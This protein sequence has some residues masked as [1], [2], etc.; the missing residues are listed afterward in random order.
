MW[1]KAPTDPEVFSKQMHLFPSLSTTQI[2]CSWAK[3]KSSL[4][5]R[6]WADEIFFITY[7]PVKLNVY[8]DIY[9]LFQK[10]AKVSPNQ[11]IIRSHC[12]K[13]FHI[14]TVFC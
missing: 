1:E 10:H 2:I 6:N 9:F 3:D 11:K 8:Q 5:S 13:I 12:F 7:L 14:I 4:V